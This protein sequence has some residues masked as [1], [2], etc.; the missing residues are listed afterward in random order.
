[1]AKLRFQASLNADEY[2]KRGVLR[3]DD[4]VILK[5]DQID[6]ERIRSELYKLIAKNEERLAKGDD[7]VLLDVVIDIHYSHRSIKSN[8]LLWL[9]Y[10]KQAEILNREA[11]QVH[12]IT[13]KELYDVDM[14]DYAPVH[15]K[16]V[17][18]EFVPAIIAFA[19]NDPDCEFK[20]HLVSRSGNHDGYIELTFRETS[21][22]W[23]TMAMTGFIEAKIAELEQ[24]GRDRYNDGDVQKIVTD[25]QTMMKGNKNAKTANN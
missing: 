4:L 23:D 18:A 25:F 24:M 3:Y 9:I 21:S 2:R 5:H 11:K 1:M 7:A 8:N 13:P 22:F 15:V 12:R 14:V 6:R 19:E 20:G 16:K 17:L 10:T